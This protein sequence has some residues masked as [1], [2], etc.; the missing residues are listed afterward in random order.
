MSTEGVNQGRRLLLVG[1]T[2]VVGAV[3]AV[4]AAVPF[5]QSWWPSAKAK[6]AGAPVVADISKLE[7]GQRMTVEWRGRPVWIMRRTPEAMATLKEVEGQL[8]DPASAESSQPAYATNP[9]RSHQ[10]HPE[11]AVIVGICTHLGCSPLYRPD[12][13][14]ADLGAEWKG[15]FF[16]PCH[17]SKFDMAGRVFQSVPAPLN[18]EVPPYYFMSESLIKIGEDGGAA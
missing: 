6:S 4:G 17:G 1:A 5:V 18:L 9:T 2:S 15:G 8:R 16:C 11:I 10:D 7:L 3:G 14:P 12:V 13:A